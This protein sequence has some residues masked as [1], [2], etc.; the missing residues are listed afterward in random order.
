[1]FHIALLKLEYMVTV[2]FLGATSLFE[3]GKIRYL[4]KDTIYGSTMYVEMLYDSLADCFDVCKV[5]LF[6]K[7]GTYIVPYQS[8]S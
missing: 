8:M 6:W 3:V 1:M 4:E 5:E 7:D 2:L